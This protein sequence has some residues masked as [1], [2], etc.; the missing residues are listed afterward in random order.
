MSDAGDEAWSNL[1]E[2]VL[3]TLSE[4]A[5]ATLVD[6][7][8]QHV[9]EV[10]AWRAEAVRL[11]TKLS[12]GFAP[13][14]SYVEPGQSRVLA[15][16]DDTK[17]TELRTSLPAKFPQLA[18]PRRPLVCPGDRAAPVVLALGEAPED[19]NAPE[20]PEAPEA[21]RGGAVIV[22]CSSQNAEARARFKRMKS[23]TGV[24]IA[25]RR[26]MAPPTTQWVSTTPSSAVAH[27]ECLEPQAVDNNLGLSGDVA[28]YGINRY[29]SDGGMML[30]QDNHT[31]IV[32]FAQ[33]LV[34]SKFFD[35]AVCIAILASCITIGIEVQ[36]M[37]TGCS[38]GVR[39]FLNVFEH[40]FTAVFTLELLVRLPAVGW[41]G[42]LPTTF[43]GLW[44]FLDALLVLVSAIL[45]VWVLPVIY[46]ITGTSSAIDSRI[47]R[48]LTAMRAL[49]LMR[50]MRVVRQVELFREVWLL[51][52][53]ISDSMRTLFWTVFVIVLITYIFSVFGM[54]LI[55]RL[56]SDLY[57]DAPEGETKTDLA[58]CLLTV[59][60]L[61]RFMYSL[62]IVL[63]VDGWNE[64][65]VKPITRFIPWAWV[66][67]FSY[68]AVGVLV[69]MN[70]VTA[71]LVETALSTSK[72][73]EESQLQAKEKVKSTEIKKLNQLFVLMDVDGDGT[74]SWEE[75]K[76]AFDNPVI[77][78][79]WKLLDFEPEECKELFRLLDH[80]DGMIPIEDF[81]DGLTRMKGTAQAKDVF[82]MMKALEDLAQVLHGMSLANPRST[83]RKRS[84]RMTRKA[85]DED[86]S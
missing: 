6:L 86:S 15:Q 72:S 14:V 68:L 61:D 32:L 20:A 26:F 58:A 1:C 31:G 63:T 52:R 50:L 34:A 60:T 24:I 75:F 10:G 81:F 38:D 47:F 41:R 85:Q 49:R 76:C 83:T 33:R 30:S 19:P 67:F 39:V 42:Y 4:H 62:V 51:L 17:V 44:N 65:V 48:A 11:G 43:A 77:A 53:G 2:Q 56:L 9:A 78:N 57:E 80:G 18:A 64:T 5:R 40:I 28:P 7:T 16:W 70:L 21:P 3:A 69:L 82:F 25:M 37:L 84:V 59:G 29:S 35:I 55:S 8:R 71:I 12:G 79:K 22:N 13:P 54:V 66:Y 23:L 45:V 73:D 36:V 74:L 46:A 27:S